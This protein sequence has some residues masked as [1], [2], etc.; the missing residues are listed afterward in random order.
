MTLRRLIAALLCLCLLP[1]NTLTAEL[2]NIAPLP[3]ALQIKLLGKVLSFDRSLDSHSGVV[4]I[5][6]IY[7]A[8]YPES[9]AAKVELIRASRGL[10]SPGGMQLRFKPIQIE[11]KPNF[12][13]VFN[14]VTVQ[15][16]YVM[17]LR[18]LDVNALTRAASAAGV[19]T[20]S[21]VPDYVY[22]GIAVTVGTREGR[23][24]IYVNLKA[25]RA[26]GSDFSSQLLKLANVV[27]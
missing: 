4:E 12:R 9:E 27:D 21:G 13:D 6:V 5:G 24:A 20:F 15:A 2:K 7:Q 14:A 1:V 26:Q 23:P 17:P 3:S 11:G 19:R 10:A 18:G 16:V 25:A 8:D 22:E